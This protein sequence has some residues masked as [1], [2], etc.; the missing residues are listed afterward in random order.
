MKYDSLLNVLEY[1]SFSLSQ[2]H[3]ASPVQFLMCM[4]VAWKASATA[5]ILK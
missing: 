2:E 5:K 1:I 3:V 4:V